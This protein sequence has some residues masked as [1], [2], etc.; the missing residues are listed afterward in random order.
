MAIPNNNVADCSRFRCIV[1]EIV[2][3][4]TQQHIK[5]H[6]KLPWNQSN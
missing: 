6:T 4:D 5:E 3:I 2:A 1:S